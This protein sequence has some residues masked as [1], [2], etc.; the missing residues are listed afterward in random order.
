MSYLFH[1]I[2]H[3]SRLL[4]AA[5]LDVHV[6]RMPE[7]A[8]ALSH[9][10]IGSRSDFYFTLRTLLVHR[11]QDFETFADAFRLFWRRPAGEHAPIDPRS[12]WER[13][14]LRN[15]QVDLRAGDLGSEDDEPSVRTLSEIVE[16]VAPM[17]YSA[18]EVSRT[19]DFA[20][21][22]DREMSEAKAMLDALHWQPGMRRTQRWVAGRGAISDFR[23]MVRRNMHHGGE[24]LEIPSRLRKQKQRPLV[25]LCDISG[26][27]E[28][29]S[30]ML[31][32]FMH[33]LATHIGHVEA[34]V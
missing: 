23:R 8:A 2:L 17:S 25:L 28:R 3:F 24:P 16:T 19:K 30:R 14:R 32:H 18:H 12:L 31:L 33:A 22:T 11:H 20:E 4:H 10:D 29:Y 15:P 5:G 7:L 6:G 13:Q 21:F 26:S 1:N 34:F 27:M 9:I